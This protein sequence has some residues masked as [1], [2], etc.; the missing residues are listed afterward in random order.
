MHAVNDRSPSFCRCVVSVNSLTWIEGSRTPVRTKHSPPLWLRGKPACIARLQALPSGLQHRGGRSKNV[1][2]ALSRHPVEDAP[3]EPHGTVRD[4]SL[5][6]L[7][8]DAERCRLCW[9]PQAFSTGSESLRSE[10]SR[11]VALETDTPEKIIVEQLLPG[12][13]TIREAQ[14]LR[15]DTLC[16]RQH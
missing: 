13:A 1:A 15:P 8:R 2:D 14:A 7:V 4:V 12:E 16:L 6:T 11:V 5:G 3:A 10:A 9:G